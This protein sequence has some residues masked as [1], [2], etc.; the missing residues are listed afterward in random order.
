MLEKVT[1]ARQKKE[2]LIRGKSGGDDPK[3]KSDST[4][5]FFSKKMR[6]YRAECGSIGARA[7]AFS[8]SLPQRIY[9]IQHVE[10]KKK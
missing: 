1:L 10:E 7:N 3:F 4:V 9:D 8:H 6:A 2:K 5:R